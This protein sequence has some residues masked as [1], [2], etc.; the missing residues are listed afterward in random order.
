VEVVSLSELG[1]GGSELMRL[2]KTGVVNV[3]EI[4]GRYVAGELP[5][6]EILEMPGIFPDP[7]TAK[8]AILAWKPTEA[9]VLAQGANA[10][11][12][13]MAAYPDQ[14]IFSKKPIRTLEDFQG[15]KTRVH[16]VALSQL[17]AGLGGEPL[18]IAFSEVYT[19]ME[20]GT[21][22]AAFTGTKPGYDQRWY[23]V[24]KYLVGPISM[25]P[26]VSFSINRK[27][28]KR[29]PKDIQAIMQ[30]EALNIIEKGALEEVEVWNKQGIEKNVEKGMELM[31]FDDALR[32]EIKQTLRTKVIPDWLDRTKHRKVDGKSS[33]QL[34]NEIIAPLVGYKV[35]S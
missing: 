18:T 8:K 6:M 7:E 5:L 26:H 3:A 1:F 25:R 35:G 2:I 24:S 27:T 16:S 23:E 32:D 12:L 28:W 29:L 22:D 17:V 33:E 4:Y 11:L 15:L 19:A 21:V 14:A 31:P 30:E 10:V 9:K 20:R 13:A 34:F